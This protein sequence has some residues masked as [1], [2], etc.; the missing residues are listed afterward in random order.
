LGRSGLM[1]LAEAEK[2]IEEQK[3]YQ[4]DT[5]KGT[6]KSGSKY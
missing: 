3:K 2:Y 6:T 5:F 4:T 1:D